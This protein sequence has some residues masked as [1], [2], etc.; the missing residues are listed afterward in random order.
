VKDENNGS[1]RSYAGVPLGI[2]L[3]VA[4]LLFLAVEY[5]PFDLGRYGWPVFIV[6]PG[7]AMIALGTA[8]RGGSSR[9]IVPGTIVIVTGLVLAVQNAF[10]LW[11]TWSYAWAL[12]APGGVGLGIA[13]EGVIRGD[14][15]KVS[16]GS[17]TALIGL[18]MFILF[19]VFFEGVV[20]ISG[21]ELG[22][23]GKL[24]APLALIVGGVALL[25]W[26]LMRPP[27]GTG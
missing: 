6:L 22:F 7:V 27:K 8:N 25:F 4:G 1:L 11:A 19:G 10:D 3:I 14:Q 23:A 21:F 5:L 17:R 15:A 13:L 20:Q 16:A 2:V 9:L 26:R 12:V 24:V 18:G